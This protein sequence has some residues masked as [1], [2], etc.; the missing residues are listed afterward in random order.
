MG[1]FLRQLQ[2]VY[3]RV[4]MEDVVCIVI[5]ESIGALLYSISSHM[6][7]QFYGCFAEVAAVGTGTVHDCNIASTF[8]KELR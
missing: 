8:F 2:R 6:L 7:L 5:T 1:I 3:D 4:G